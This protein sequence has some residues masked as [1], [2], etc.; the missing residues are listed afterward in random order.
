MSKKHFALGF[1]LVLTLALSACGRSISQEGRPFENAK[2]TYE[3]TGTVKG[4][5]TVYYNGYKTRSEVNTSSGDEESPV[6]QNITIINDGD[7]IYRVD[8]NSKLALKQSNPYKE[9]LNSI[10]KGDKVEFRERLALNLNDDEDM[11]KSTGEKVI[12]GKTCKLYSIGNSETVCLWDGVILYHELAIE[13]G[14]AIQQAIGMELDTEQSEDLFSL[15][16]GASVQ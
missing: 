1:V 14:L 16:E 13:G 5:E 9:K 11:P 12:L 10:N 15:P 4:T 7:N 3:W 2:I 8:E 6:K